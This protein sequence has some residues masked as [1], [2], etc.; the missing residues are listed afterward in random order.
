MFLPVSQIEEKEKR[1]GKDGS[2]HQQ[3][4]QQLR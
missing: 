2:C 1:E 4:M 3:T